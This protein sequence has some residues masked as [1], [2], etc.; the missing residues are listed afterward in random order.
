M[1]AQITQLCNHR[2]L[3][4][5][6]LAIAHI[7]GI[8]ASAPSA[9]GSRSVM[10]WPAPGS[11]SRHPADRLTAGVASVH[12]VAAGFRLGLSEVPYL[13]GVVFV[14]TMRRATHAAVI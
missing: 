10:T 13:W 4:R 3:G 5:N 11:R 14:F 1:D 8:G 9:S 12:R 7:G 2:G 6:F